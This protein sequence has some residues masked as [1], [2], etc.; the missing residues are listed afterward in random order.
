LQRACQSF[1]C[2]LPAVGLGFQGLHLAHLNTFNA[3]GGDIV[4]YKDLKDK[5][6]ML[7]PNITTIYAMSFWNLDKQEPL[8]VEVPPE[9]GVG[10][11]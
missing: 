5:A 8:I 9:C 7:T 2:A 4:L 6:G 10:K 11:C 1:I 3:K